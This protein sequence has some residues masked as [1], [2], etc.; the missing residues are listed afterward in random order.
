MDPINLPTRQ[1]ALQS[2]SA[3]YPK[4][5]PSS[6]RRRPNR[7]SGRVAKHRQLPGKHLKSPVDDE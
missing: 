6:F 2:W 7:V 5:R 4:L 3:F 1:D